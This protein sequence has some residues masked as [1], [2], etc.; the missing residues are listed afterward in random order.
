MHA[1]KATRAALLLA[2]AAWAFATGAAQV[3]ATPSLPLYGENIVVDLRDLQNPAYLPATRYMRSGSNIVIDYEVAPAGFGPLRADFGLPRVNLGELVPGNYTVEARLFKMGDPTQAP[4]VV[5]QSLAVVPPER[6]GLYLIPRE[7]EAFAAT[8]VLLR[9]AAY[10]EPGSMHVTQNAN[11]LR[12][13]FDF[14]GNAPVGS[15]TPPG[16]TSYAAI[17]LPALAPGSY[18]VEGWGR[19]KSNGAAAERYF[20]QAFT[21]ASA[22]P[23]V[24]Y[25][26]ESTDHYFITAAPGDVAMLD[27]GG[28]GGWKRTGQKFKGWL[29]MGDAPPGA[30][31]V[32]RFYAKGPN[33][34]FYT[35]NA[36]DCEY[37]KAIESQQRASAEARGE[38]F[39]GWAFE[40]IAF[41][42]LVPENGQCPGGTT[43]VYRTFNNRAGQN[44]SNHRFSTDAQQRAAM[45]LSSWADEGVAFC[46]PP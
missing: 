23:I 17:R 9:S 33:S 25:Y 46:S 45:L 4:Q 27:N 29:R 21:V 38:P 1:L 14:L 20:T 43:A 22:V 31:A 28:M 39:L 7:P 5:T 3:S 26:A 19:D 6:W 32:C 10:F 40:N 15:P 37:L 24:E 13:D 8:D 36:G 41:Y 18:T 11:V 30:K 34:H 35:G 2:S 44:D 16:T 12:V 42:A